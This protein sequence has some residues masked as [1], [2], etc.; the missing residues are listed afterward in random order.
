MLPH[1]CARL[2]LAN[3]L[4]HVGCLQGFA[5]GNAQTAGG[6]TGNQGG[7]GGIGGTGIGALA[8]CFP[9]T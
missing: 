5:G 8:D 9:S 2:P 7:A 3:D 4:A 1:R 6:L